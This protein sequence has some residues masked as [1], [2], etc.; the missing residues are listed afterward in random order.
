M[1]I[2]TTVALRHAGRATNELVTCDDAG[3]GAAAVL[4]AVTGCELA[5]SILRQF[6]HLSLLAP[7]WKGSV[8]PQ[9]LQFAK[10]IS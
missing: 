8:A 3:T 10:K 2:S 7:N 1:A 9:V 6:S 4:P 5:A